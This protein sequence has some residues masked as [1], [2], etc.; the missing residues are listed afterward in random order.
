M[1]IRIYFNDEKASEKYKKLQFS[2][3]PEDTRILKEINKVIAILEEDPF[4]GTQIP[5]RLIPKEY[6]K[7]FKPD[8]LWKYD[9]NKSWRLIYWVSSDDNGQITLLI[10]WMDH[11]RYDKLFGYSTS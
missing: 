9:L 4:S 8:N 2:F 5:K 11:K 3:N 6:N 10:D 7:I 1:T